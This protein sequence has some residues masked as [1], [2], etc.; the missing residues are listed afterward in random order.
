[1]PLHDVR[2]SRQL[3]VD[4]EQEVGARRRVGVHEHESVRSI[5]SIAEARHHP[6]QRRSLSLLSGLNALVHLDASDAGGSG[7]IGRGVCAI[8]GDY[9]SREE[10]SWIVEPSHA[11]QRGFD[12]PFLVMCRDEQDESVKRLAG[13]GQL[14][15]LPYRCRGD[16]ERT[17]I[18]GHHG[19][20]EAPENSDCTER[21]NAGADALS[22][23]L[24]TIVVEHVAIVER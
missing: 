20:P 13:Q 18:P 14:A 9:V 10:V 3:V 1:M 2:T 11:R 5:G 17:E 19:E 22:P 24:A 4:E 16:R 6:L 8:V 15:T 21:E 7:D 12:A 23:D